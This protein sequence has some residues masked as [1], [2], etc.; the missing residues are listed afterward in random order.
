LIKTFLNK[1]RQKYRTLTADPAA[2]KKTLRQILKVTLWGLA[3][4]VVLNFLL[5]IFVWAG[6][7][8]KLPSGRE[9]S[10]IENQLSSEIYAEN[11]ELLGKY[12]IYD[13]SH[14][15]LNQISENVINSLIATEDVRFYDHN[16]IDFK[17]LARVIFKTILLGDE[18]S[19]G[20]STITQQLAKNLFARKNQSAWYMPVNKLKEMIIARRLENVY[21][22]NEILTLYL[23]T[24]PFGE[25]VYGIS[26]ASLRYFNKNPLDLTIEEAAVLVGML[27]ATTYYNPRVQTERATTRRNV[28]IAQLRRYNYITQE[29]ADSLSNLPIEINYNPMSHNQGPAPYFRETLRKQ[30]VELL[31]DYN[32][33]NQTDYNLFTDGLK[34]YTSINYDLQ[35]MAE[36]AMK[37]QVSRQ[38][39]ILDNYYKN[40][41]RQSARTLLNSLMKSSDRYQSLVARSLTETEINENFNT[42]Q[43]IDVYQW[44]ESE[45]VEITPLDSIFMMQKL[46]HAGLLSLDPA[47]GYVRAWVGGID[48]RFFQYDHVLAQRQAGSTFKPFLYATALQMGVDPCEYVSNEQKLYEEYD[49]WSPVNSNREYTGYY[50]M[51]GALA[52]SVNTISAHYIDLTGV[53]PVIENAHKSGIKSY[54]PPVPSLALGTASVNLL[55]L[56]AAY[57]TYL[58][59]GTY[60]DPQWLLLIEDKN[61]KILYKGRPVKEQAGGFNAGVSMLTRKMMEA[62]VDSGTAGS[63]RYT[64]GLTGDLAGKTGTTQN[65]TDTWFIGFTP[66]LVTGVWTGLENPAFTKIYKS[67]VN[68]SNSAVP[69][70]GE[71]HRQI[72]SHRSTRKYVQG[73]FVPLPDSLA[74]KLACSMYLDELP[75]ENW[76]DVLFGTQKEK[77]RERKPDDE[78]RKGNRLR[79]WLESLF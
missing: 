68:S 36:A 69:F 31:N 16:G 8:G 54:L 71:Y 21:S 17:S 52:N 64:Y 38:Q 55:E 18:S 43:F 41:S 40:I 73:G 7:F 57:S 70:W 62:V 75:P 12:F 34:I 72:S 24:V 29:A 3:G 37:R 19:G 15:N 13:R 20:G 33:K 67:P 44:N 63:L 77:P 60:I 46:L 58:N 74:S 26:A 78:N 27:K 50:S 4:I 48:F 23:N 79:K 9:L 56:T 49:N 45:P 10:A 42:S 25:N 14:A 76:W 30:I 59:N 66:N 47:N 65:N 51:T 11:G 39:K 2:R 6:I 22:K 1:I 35:L 5:F 32:I 53:L 28:V 61:G